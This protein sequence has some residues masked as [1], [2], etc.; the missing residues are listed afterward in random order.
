MIGYRSMSRG[1]AYFLSRMVYQLDTAGLTSGSAVV[2]TEARSV[3]ASA[4]TR[5]ANRARE[6]LCQ[7]R[8]GESAATANWAAASS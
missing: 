2:H 4:V 5:S 8:V 1:T 3:A 7:I 6:M